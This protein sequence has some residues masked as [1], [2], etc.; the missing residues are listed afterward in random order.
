MHA[1][2]GSLRDVVVLLSS[3]SRIFS[4]IPCW[5]CLSS[6]S[7]GQEIQLSGILC[8]G[9]LIGDHELE[10]FVICHSSRLDIVL[11]LPC[12]HIFS[13]IPC[14]L[15]LST[16]SIIWIGEEMQ[17]SGIL[18]AGKLIGDHEWERFVIC[19]SSRLDIVLLCLPC[20]HIFSCIP[21]LLYLSTL[22]IIWTGEDMQLS[23]YCELDN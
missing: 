1:S 3:W 18:W 16:L 8:A 6:L 17:L 5:F 11:C 22:S 14:L 19:H 2:K 10:S 23:E 12:S 21:C 4:C 13:C 9:K 7:I 20:S 15:Y